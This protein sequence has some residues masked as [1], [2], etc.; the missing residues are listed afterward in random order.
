VEELVDAFGRYGLTA[1]E[2][3]SPRFIRLGRIQALQSDGSI[4]AD[5]RRA[6]D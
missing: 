5:L 3:T 4:G 2:L 6:A 1:N